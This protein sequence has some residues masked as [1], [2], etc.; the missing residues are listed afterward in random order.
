MYI[1]INVRNVSIHALLAECDRSVCFSEEARKAFQSTHSLRSATGS[2]VTRGGLYQFQSTHSLRSATSILALFVVATKS[3][4]PRTPCGVRHNFFVVLIQKPLVSI[5]ALLAECDHTS[6]QV[7]HPQISF[8]PRTPCGVR[9]SDLLNIR[10]FL[11]FQSTHSLR[12]ATV[13]T[14][15]LFYLF[16]V[17]IHALLAEC[18]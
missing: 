13:L 1:Y 5:H 10:L 12:S 18:D 15:R 14:Y 3:F 9:Q 2:S 8:N 7:S 4:N 6:L 17:S 16:E 11:Q